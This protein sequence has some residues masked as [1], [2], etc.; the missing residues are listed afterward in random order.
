[1]KTSSVVR[2]LE[3]YTVNTFFG[4]TQTPDLPGYQGRSPC[5]VS[6]LWKTRLVRLLHIRLE[7]SPPMVRAHQPV[8]VVDAEIAQVIEDVAETEIDQYA[9]RAIPHNVARVLEQIQAG[10]RRCGAFS[11]CQSNARHHIL[12]GRTDV[13][14]TRCNARRA[15]WPHY[16]Y[17]RQRISALLAIQSVSVSQ[18]ERISTRYFNELLKAVEKK[19]RCHFRYLG[20]PSTWVV[21]PKKSSQQCALCEQVRLD[22]LAHRTGSGISSKNHIGRVR[23]KIQTTNPEPS[24]EFLRDEY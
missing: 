6:S 22:F 1:M 11:V 10:T 15:I 14:C 4:H 13:P 9:V 16:G 21:T 19:N 20:W 7:L 2:Y 12:H 17:H 24:G 8:D 5:L 23:M 3:A 18:Q